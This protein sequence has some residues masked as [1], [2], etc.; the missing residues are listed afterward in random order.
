MRGAGLAYGEHWGP[1]PRI[2]VAGIAFFERQAA[3]GAR[4][5]RAVAGQIQ[6]RGR[7]DRLPGHLAARADFGGDR[8]TRPRIRRQGATGGGAGG[9]GIAGRDAGGSGGGM[10]GVTEDGSRRNIYG[11]SSYRTS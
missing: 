2:A 3:Y 9:G 6:C 1:H 5:D 4:S 8:I 10:A 7:R 11:F